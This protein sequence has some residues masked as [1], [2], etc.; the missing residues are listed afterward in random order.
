MKEIKEMKEMFKEMKEWCELVRDAE[1]ETGDGK[2]MRAKRVNKM[3]I[4]QANAKHA[5]NKHAGVG[6]GLW[7]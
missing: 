2:L 3:D 1:N 6:M 5:E 7:V 4:T